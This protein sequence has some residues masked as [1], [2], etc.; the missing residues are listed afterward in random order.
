MAYAQ[1]P[2][3]GDAP[4]QLFLAPVVGSCITLNS[5][6]I[7]PPLCGKLL[8]C[9]GHLLNLTKNYPWYVMLCWGPWRD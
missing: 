8:E 3:P 4:R 6:S 2:S 1:W 7:L 5:V 9:S